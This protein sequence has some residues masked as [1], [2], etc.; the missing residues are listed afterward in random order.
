MKNKKSFAAASAEKFEEPIE[1]TADEQGDQLAAMEEMAAELNAQPA[2]GTVELSLQFDPGVFEALQT[3]IANLQADNAELRAQLAN[4]ND[5]VDRA[6]KLL[7]TNLEATKALKQKVLEIQGDPRATFTVPKRATQPNAPL[8]G[9]T[10]SGANLPHPTPNGAMGMLFSA[11][12]GDGQQPADLV[13]P[14]E[15]ELDPAQAAVMRKE[16]MR[17]RVEANMRNSQKG[18]RS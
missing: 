13:L 11:R 3:E 1:P 17:L 2:Q 7:Q 14:E 4:Q 12:A 6:L 18:G 16:A 5:R 15:Q 9:L 8:G 10:L